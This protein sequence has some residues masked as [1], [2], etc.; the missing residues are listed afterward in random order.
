MHS[1]RTLFGPIGCRLKPYKTARRR[2]CNDLGHN[3]PA[4]KR[5]QRA[6]ESGLADLSLAHHLPVAPWQGELEMSSSLALERLGGGRC[7]NVPSG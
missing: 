1:G 3:P 4:P 5:A 7:T 2:L 6:P